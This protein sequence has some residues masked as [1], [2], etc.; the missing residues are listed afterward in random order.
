MNCLISLKEIQKPGKHPGYLDSSYKR[1]FGSLNVVPVLS[2]DRKHFM[3]DIAPKFTKHMS[4]SGVQQKLSLTIA[5]DELVPTETDGCYILKPSP[6]QFPEASENEHLSMLIGE[7][8]GIETPPCGLVQFSDGERAYIIK[9]FDRLNEHKLHQVDMTAAFDLQRD[10]TGEYKYGLSYEEA[11]SK[12]REITG[13]K[14]PPVR[15][16]F[17]RV[18]HT[19][20]IANGDHHLKN[21]SVQMRTPNREG[22]YDGLTPQYDSLNTRPYSAEETVFALD[23]LANDEFTPQYEKLGYYTK[24]DFDELALRIGLTE[25]A[26][27]SLYKTVKDRYAGVHQLIDA[28]YL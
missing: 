22:V 14:L 23:L 7:H 8:F 12:I 6:E 13:G 24:A 2:F 27:A 18:L 11:G 10:K 26:A 25:R 20:L 19:F 5:N 3:T 9:R 21:I 16:F 17:L 1:L 15:D 4:I 28:S